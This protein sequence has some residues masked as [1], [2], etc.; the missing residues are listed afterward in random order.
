[1]VAEEERKRE[2][3]SINRFSRKQRFKNKMINLEFVV[4]E[5]DRM[6]IIKNVFCSMSNCLVENM[7]KSSCALGC[8][9]KI[10]ALCSLSVRNRINLLNIL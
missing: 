3:K 5:N 8:V 7:K 9:R 6:L 4:R 10:E 2:R 1:M